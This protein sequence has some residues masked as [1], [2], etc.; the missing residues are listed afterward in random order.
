[1]VLWGKRRLR[2][3]F[4]NTETFCNC[5]LVGPGCTAVSTCTIGED[6][7]TS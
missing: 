2:V 6:I 7:K 5:E 3:Y 4:Y 1:M